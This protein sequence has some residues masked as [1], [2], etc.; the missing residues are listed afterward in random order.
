MIER[1]N[2]FNENMDMDFPSDYNLLQNLL[3]HLRDKYRHED[4]VLDSFE[5]LANKM[6]SDGDIRKVSLEEFVEENELDIEV[7]DVKP[8][9]KSYNSPINK[10]TRSRETYS[11]GGCG[12][13][14]STYGSGGC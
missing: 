6:V 10:A 9:P 8:T 11:S 2:T 7:E 5:E 3:T 1:F 12:P 13:S 14:R 4:D